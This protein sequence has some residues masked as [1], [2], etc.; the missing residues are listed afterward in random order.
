M[1]RNDDGHKDSI[2]N[3]AVEKMD[4]YACIIAVAKE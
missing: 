1:E 2:I 4:P 3:L